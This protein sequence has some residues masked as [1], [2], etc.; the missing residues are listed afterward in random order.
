MLP[1][2]AAPCHIFGKGKEGV[3]GS[4]R[5]QAQDVFKYIHVHIIDAN[6]LLRALL[7]KL[8]RI[9][10]RDFRLAFRMV[11]AGAV[12]KKIA[13]PV[14]GD[15]KG[16]QLF[17]RLTVGDITGV[18][19]ACSPR[20]AELPC[21]SLQLF[22]RSPYKNCKAT[23]QGEVAGYSRAYDTCRPGDNGNFSFKL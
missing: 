1:P 5:V 16:C 11:A 7:A 14:G 4:H 8:S 20:C 17:H 19:R 13:F 22:L 3:D 12:D 10:C 6:E 18:S 2:Y 15:H 23:A 9:E 21:K